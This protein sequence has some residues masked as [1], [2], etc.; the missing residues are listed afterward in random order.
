MDH[1]MKRSPLMLIKNVKTPTMILAGDEDY[2]TPIANMEE[3]FFALKLLKVETVL[4]RFPGEPHGI[5]RYPSH[6]VAK[7]QYI[8][9]PS[10]LNE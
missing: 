8:I 6:Q 4:I 2:L 10:R 1:Y 5:F 7:V 3:Y 9:E